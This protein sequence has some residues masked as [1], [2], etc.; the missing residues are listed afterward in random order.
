METEITALL[1]GV[2]SGRRYWVR[3]PQWTALP[4]VVLYRVDGI[5]GY[6]L[7]GRDNVVSSRVQATCTA[8][9]YAAARQTADAVIAALDGVTTRTDSPPGNIQAIFIESDG[10]DIASED[11]GSVSSLFAVAVDFT[12]YHEP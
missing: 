10:R 9:T 12:V 11:A 1:A 7:Q 5:P 2:A 8:T 4:H 3:A 6:H